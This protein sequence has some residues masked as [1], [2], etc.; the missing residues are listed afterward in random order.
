MGEMKGITSDDTAASPSPPT[1]FPLV[2]SCGSPVA[3]V[4]LTIGC[5]A[6]EFMPSSVTYSWMDDSR[7]AFPSDKYRQYPPVQRGGTFSSTSQLSVSSEE[8]ENSEFFICKV[9]SS[10]YTVEIPVRKPVIVSTDPPEISLV[11]LPCKDVKTPTFVLTCIVVD[12]HSEDI[13]VK[14]SVNGIPLMDEK[15]SLI[16]N[17]EKGKDK[18]FT[19][20]SRQ[21]ISRDEW[22]KGSTFSCIVTHGKTT[23]NK[24]I[25]MCT[26][27]SSTEPTIYLQKPPFEAVLKGKHVS[28]DCLVVGLKDSIISWIVDGR[29]KD[30]QSVD[31]K[32]NG[33]NTQSITKRLTVSAAEWK[34]YNKISCKVKH[35]CFTKEASITRETGP[36]KKPVLELLRP[37]ED[38]LGADSAE[39]VCIITGFFPSDIY[40][41]WQKGDKEIDAGLYKN[42]PVVPEKGGVSYSTFSRLTIPKNEWMTRN[43][44]SCVAAHGTERFTAKTP[45]NLFACSSTEPTIYLQKPP[46]EAVLKGKHVSADCIVV[47]LKDSIVSWI[48][49]GREKDSQSVDSKI[50][51]NNTQSITKRLTVSAAEWKSYNKISC[52]VKHPCFTKEASITKETGPYKKP[53]LE[54]LRPSEDHLGADSAELVCIITGFFP[55]DIYVKWQKGD[56]EID[57]ALYKNNPVVPEKGGVSY[58]TFSRLTIPKNEWTTRNTYSCVAAHGT[59]RFTA[60]TPDNLFACSSTEPTIYLQKPPFE[61]VL[62]GKHVSADC[63]VVGLKDSI[64]SWIVDGREKDSQSV[65]SKLNGNNTQSI[66]KRLTVSAAEWKSYNKISC[67]VKHPCFTKE[68]S[69]TKE[70]GPYKKP[71]LELL[72]PSEDHLGA[73][74]AEL[75][76]IITGF[77]PSDIYVK[78]QKGDK[79]I[80]SALYKNNPVVP[81]KGGVSYSTFSRLTIPKNEWMTRN[82]YSC[83]AAHGTERFTAKTPDNLFACSSTEPTIYLQKPPFEAVLKGKHVS[84]DCLVVGLKDSIISWIVDGREK[85]SQSVDSKLNGNN[86]QSITKR[87]T[88]S[89]A[90]WKSYNKISCQVKHPCFTKEASI[91]RE[92]G[93]YKKPVL[94]LLRPS[95]DHLGAD[96]AELVCI[97]T[98][99][100]P[101]DIYVKWQKGDKEIDSALYKNNPVVPEKGGV[102]YSTFSRLTIPKN[103]WTNRNTYSCVA[104]HGTERFTA[105]T[106]DNLFACSSTEPTIYLQ[107]PPFEA[108]LKGKHVSADCLVV[109]LKD[110]I[111]SWIVDGREKDSKS[112]DSKIN[113]NNTQ[114][115]T[116]RLTVS[117]AEWKSYNKISCQVKHP[118]F[119]KEA[120]ITKETG[121][122]KKPVLELLRPSEDHLGADSAELVC[123]ITGFFPS[124]IY[125]KWQKGDK[126]IDSALYK[127][128]PVVPEKGGVSYST[129]SRLTIPKNE[130][131][132]RNT[133]SCVAAH[134]TERFTAKTPDNLFA[135]SSTEPTIYLQKPPFEAVLKGKH[136]SADCL[137]VGLKDSIISWIVDGREKDSKS[138]DSKINGNNTQSITKR[139]TVS[140]AEWKSYNKI[141][142]QVKHPCFTKEA[143]ITKETGPYKKPVLELL[144]PSEDHL[145]AD[146]A[147]LVCII[148]GFFPSDIYVKWQKG[149]KE[150]DSALYK[151]NPVVPEKGGVSYSTFSRLTIPKNEWTNRNTYSC[152]AAH[153]TERFTAKTPDN[154]FACSSTEPTIYL[155][156]PPFEAVLKGKHVSADCLVVGLKDSIISWIVDGGEKDS[157]SVDNKLNGNNTQSITKRLTVSAAEWKSYNKISCQVK[158]PCF[159]KEASITRETGPYKK[160]VL[161]LLRP[162]EDHLGADSA[163]LVCIITG[164]FPSDI[165]VKW[166]KGDKEID[167]ALY[168]NN[169]V[170]PEK[171]GVSY[172]TFS[173]LTIPK[174]EWTTRNTYSCVAAHGTERFTAKTPDNLFACSSTEPTIYLQKPP[175]EA[176]LKGKHVS[177]DCLVV[178]LKDSIISW[179]VDGREKDSQSVDSKLNGNNTQSITKRLTVSAAEW[180]SYNKISCQVKHPCFTKEASITKETGPYKKPVL[181][182]LRPSEDHLG[183]DSAELVC[184]IT[185]F[186]PSD[187]Y[188]K[189]QKGDKEID[190][191]LYK[192]NP[193]VPEKGGVS[194]STFS[195]LTIPK[196]EWTTRNTYSCVAAHG[197][198]R[199]TA[200]TPD[201]LFAC[202]ST[203]PTIYLQ[204]PPFEAVLKGEH[205]SADCLVVG[206]K[207]SIVSWIVD[208]REKD[209]QSVDSKINGN[210][211]QS[212]T[213]RLTVSAAEWKSYNKI[214]C[215]VKHPCFTKEAS[216]T[217]ETGPYKKPVLELLRPSEDHLGA[218][219]A[220]L[221]CIITGFFP[222]DIYVKW[223]KGDKEIDAGLYKNNPVVPEKGGV[224]YSTF[225]RL[226]IP[227]NEWTTRNTYSCVAAHGT[228]R[229]TAKTP[230]N[231]FACCST[232]PTIYLQKPPFEAVFRG[233]NVSADCLVVGLK[234]SIVSWIVDGREKD[235]QSVDSKLIG[236][237]TQSI[238]KRLTVSAAE[239]K[240]YNKTSCKVK[241]PCFTKE[242]SITKE[243]GPYKKP[244]LELLR[245]SED[246]L[247][248]DSAE[249]VCIITGFFPSDIYVKWQ[250]GDKEIDSALYKNNP[251]VPEKGGASYSTVSRLT[252]PKNEWTTQNTYSCVAAH[253]TERF[254]AK[255][256]D[257]LFASVI[258]TKPT[259]H[260]LQSTSDLVCLV[261]GYSPK[262]IVINWLLNEEPVSQNYTMAQPSMGMDG[263]FSTR[264]QILYS[265]REWKPGMVYTCMV[266]HPATNTIL[267]RNISK[268]EIIEEKDFH[269]DNV[270]YFVPEDDMQ[271]VWTTACTFIILFLLSF[272]YSSFVT[273]VKV[274]K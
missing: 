23:T 231:L 248:A 220:E 249:L 254:T 258:P 262:H 126:E 91:T 221:V 159:T 243:T 186:F 157:Q 252:I 36:Y 192:N 24:N 273:V 142:C 168:K 219:S 140:A 5:L 81:E 1:L 244:V 228:E 119:T 80:D 251:V 253:G 34:S 224:S 18:A 113:G 200:K 250:K 13:T 176:V 144:R 82:T 223:Q 39:L 35:P 70:T 8:W 27:C 117:A 83:V 246:H 134:G 22:K 115:I 19:F 103:E 69:I 56:K 179:I 99:F 50:N 194:Y 84:A 139:L 46:F 47:G 85:D 122:Y 166:Q 28:A 136:V 226:T 217:R 207:D 214:S 234:D 16:L 205:V 94:E 240:S 120:S 264:S 90:E 242:A 44:Y 93:P 148:T 160:P 130:W 101:S 12:F 201:N 33:N 57:S 199:F 128:N 146:S 261:H 127:N 216:I 137:V 189:W 21:E 9:T 147:E 72:R 11:H 154:L 68:A 158:H 95:E 107:K 153:G 203:E 165:Y 167:S 31:S 52:Q 150:I 78:W 67:Q 272:L 132:T 112:V 172:S 152:V 106:P 260:L 270:D 88:V 209:S 196:N 238:T 237:N 55:S 145:G 58:S 149:D 233:E 77:F 235:S 247:G 63:L 143:S 131:T 30:S 202:S 197:T 6:T 37:S 65:D 102:S 29:E 86:T 45:D 73:D 263:K 178:G 40:V 123:I 191:A 43:T 92:T 210:N 208:G 76:C 97:I 10:T 271:G 75:V 71:V 163:E 53:V 206:L 156:K 109:G 259:I 236:N 215:Q 64:I 181:E 195:R 274:K 265:V 17:K 138:V 15:S 183:A 161:E 104:A 26:A 267:S 257:N 124:D 222:S 190:S 110:S 187:I 241:H 2:A 108:V 255:T 229:F 232:E 42:N 54:L 111:I 49:D 3:T 100:F 175:F 41:K 121:P 66:T 151:N 174:N 89:A 59:E 60:K 225:S 118:C 114:S 169:P 62:K 177:A 38:H 129:F 74:S 185:G 180:K 32:L 182:L 141:S 164:F 256:P 4:P 188:V 245:P 266:N 7:T 162:S 198:E 193:V 170:V 25:S 96:S 135:C 173:R 98:G 79:E 239:W 227:K 105:K 61:A 213:K 125:V 171:G 184:I 116:K 211:T 87:L 48:V 212:I 155:Q 268:P 269:D 230:D 51:G 133:Y 20:I 14:W 204:K 218:D